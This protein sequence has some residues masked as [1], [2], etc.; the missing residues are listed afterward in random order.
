MK[1]ALSPLLKWDREFTKG[2]NKFKKS[3]SFKKFFGET[4]I[5]KKKKRVVL[6][7]RDRELTGEEIN[8]I[9]HMFEK[10]YK[11]NSFADKI[12]SFFK[13]LFE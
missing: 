12:I 1:K 3:E 4:M 10:A 11:G 6:F 2:F 8:K 13:R 5:S 7:K 9:K